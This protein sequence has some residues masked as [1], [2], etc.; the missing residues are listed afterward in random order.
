MLPPAAPGFAVAELRVKLQAKFAVTLTGPGRYTLPLGAT[1]VHPV[2]AY[3]AAG[4][5]VN[6]TLRPDAYQP[7]AL[8][9]TAV[10][11]PAPA[12]ATVVAR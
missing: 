1:P 6:W 12:G 10:T 3:P 9:G 7:S 2:N 11:L 4:V 5:A 8:E